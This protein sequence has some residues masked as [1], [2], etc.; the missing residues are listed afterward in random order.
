MASCSQLPP[1]GRGR[2]IARQESSSAI[3][4]HLHSLTRGVVCHEKVHRG[5]DEERQEYPPGVALLERASQPRQQQEG[6]EQPRFESAMRA[7]WDQSLKR[8]RMVREEVYCA[9][10]TSE[11]IT[12]RSC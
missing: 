3:A 1:L 8:N 9:E 5:D 7:E 10:D 2:A 12:E 6:G 4:P 11:K